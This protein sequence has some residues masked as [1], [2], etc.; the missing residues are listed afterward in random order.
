[1]EPANKEL[2]RASPRNLPLTPS[3]SGSPPTPRL[4]RSLLSFPHSPLSLPPAASDASPRQLIPAPPP[5]IA[6]SLAFFRKE[7]SV[8]FRSDIPGR[9]ETQVGRWHAMR[10]TGEERIQGGEVERTADV[11][12]ERVWSPR[13]GSNVL[14]SALEGLRFV[15]SIICVPSCHNR[16]YNRGRAYNHHSHGQRP[17]GSQ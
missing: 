9:P 14:P 3:S 12:W 8:P 15:R 13:R 4:H 11:E 2:Y 1:M 6:C 7:H 16:L 10:K 5:L 17:S